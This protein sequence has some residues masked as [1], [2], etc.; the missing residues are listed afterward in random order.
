[1]TAATLRVVLVAYWLVG[2]LLAGVGSSL[3]LNECPYDD[4]RLGDMLMLAAIWP[5]ALSGALVLDR[6][7]PTRPC[8]VPRP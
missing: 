6:P 7:L 4:V 5:S 2:T 8:Q 3:R 1:M